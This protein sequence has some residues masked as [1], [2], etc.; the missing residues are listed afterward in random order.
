V[1]TFTG[2]GKIVARRADYMIEHIYSGIRLL[3]RRW[4]YIPSGMALASEQL[5]G[6]AE[7]V[8]DEIMKA[9]R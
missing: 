6:A 5:N 2:N 8:R 4:V 9:A 7:I 3:A 1:E